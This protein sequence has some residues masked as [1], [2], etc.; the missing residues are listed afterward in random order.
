MSATTVVVVQSADLAA[1]VG[2][3]AGIAGVTLG[4][5]LERLGRKRDERQRLSSD[6]ERA[7]GQ[8][9]GAMWALQEAVQQSNAPGGSAWIQIRSD[10][11][12]ALNALFDRIAAAA[13]DELNRAAIHIAHVAEAGP[14][15]VAIQDRKAAEKRTAEIGNAAREFREAMRH[16]KLKPTRER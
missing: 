4:Y 15:P 10:R 12:T 3:F 8:L 9:F 1:W 2:S 14:P 11:Q 5:W 7:S 16:A 13:S 6:V